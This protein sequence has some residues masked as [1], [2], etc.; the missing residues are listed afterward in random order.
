M[1]ISTQ[2]IARVYI[3]NSIHK[4]F[5]YIYRNIYHIL[6]YRYIITS[7]SKDPQCDQH[8]SLEVSG[9][10]WEFEKKLFKIPHPNHAPISLPVDWNPRLALL[11]PWNALAAYCQHH[12]QIW[13]LLTGGQSSLPENWRLLDAA[14]DFLSLL[15]K[16]FFNFFLI[17]FSF[18]LCVYIFFSH[19]SCTSLFT[20]L[21]NA[22]SSLITMLSL[23]S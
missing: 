18:F 7:L 14:L 5:L 3:Y 23:T 9:G 1:C 6:L 22:S 8:A 11:P 15:L 17:H 19:I 12:S 13:C 10:F 2:I 21:N 16:Y 4:Y 20:S